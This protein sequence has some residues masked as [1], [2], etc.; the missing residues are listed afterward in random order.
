MSKSLVIV[1]SP[2]KA[3]TISKI[4]GKGYVVRASAGHIRDLP[5]KEIGVD[6]AKGFI[7]KYVII[8]DKE[9]VVKELQNSAK[10]VD[11]VLLA[12][13]PDRE[14]EAI[15]WH[16]AHILQLPPEKMK[17]IQFNE[18]TKEAVQFA[19]NNPREINQN[20]V[21]AQQARRVLDRL[22]G[23]KLSP[24]LW[25]KI[26]RGLSAGRVQSVSVRLICDRE[27][28][29][30]AFQTKEYW[31]L[32]AQF[33]KDKQK[34][35]FEAE[36]GRLND[37]KPEIDTQQAMDEVLASLKGVTEY[38]VSSIKTKDRKQ[39]PQFPFI[40]SSLQ[41]EAS[42]ALNFSVKRTMIAAQQLYEGIELGSEGPIGLI[43]YMRTDSTR[44]AESAQDTAAEYIEAQYGKQ[45]LPKTRRLGKTAK[46]GQDAHEAI[47]PAEI[48]RT[49]EELKP[50]L[51]SDQFRLYRLIWQRFVSSQMSAAILAIQTIEIAG[52]LKGKKDPL[53]RLSSTQI[54][55]DGY[56]RVYL[57]AKEEDSTEEE[58]KK[59]Q[60]PILEEGEVVDLKELLP[61]QHFTQP[62]SRYSEATLVKVMEE[63]GIGR[64][65]TYA[66][67][68]ATIQDR[69]Y[70]K[71]EGRMLQPT[72]LGM[73]VNGQLVQHFPNIVDTDFT[74]N[75]ETQ[76]DEVEKGGRPWGE[77][78]A[79]F[80]EPF[81]KTLETA[82]EE[83]DRILIVTKYLCAECGLPML[84]KSSKYGNF[85]GCSGYPECKHTHPLTPQNEPAPKERPV[86]GEVCSQCH[87]EPMI[88]KYGRF[89]EYLKCSECG[90]NQPILKKV[91]LECPTCHKG[92]IVERKGR[93]GLF[94]GCSEYSSKNPD[95]CNFVLWSRP[96][97]KP[98]PECASILV[99]KPLKRGDM[100]QCSNKECGFKAPAG[101][102]DPSLVGQEEAS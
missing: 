76:L 18:I 60:V 47:R 14:G 5:T 87:H 58:E 70:V 80:Y 63:L 72:E 42:T 68:I 7:P 3:K 59:Q 96:I 83:M 35:A 85:L 1:E 9:E 26:K 55:F 71:K 21:D 89:G 52:N 67:T 56:Q 20:R 97:Q 77:L 81:L 95:S 46:G 22:V 90:H 27:Q 44:I 93:R 36:L 2:A 78:L 34:R 94:Y 73:G 11:Q 29:I 75:M 16:L 4:L 57:E 30:Q 69:G 38:K 61:K 13:D 54:K 98:C 15:A 37:K 84:Q 45:Y 40:T 101:E 62:P 66:P 25:K 10:G 48:V 79:S 100:V 50:F 82:T 28:E 19:V 31:T 23:Y 8:P 88:A 74:A 32:A 92:Q 39:E 65:S 51:S 43:T 41:R 91:G 6:I 53:F 33:A 64:P 49:P 12:P 102:F 99:F 17:R 86:P 24:L